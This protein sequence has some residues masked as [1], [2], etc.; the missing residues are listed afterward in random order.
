[1]QH[2]I[3]LSIVFRFLGI[4][5]LVFLLTQANISELMSRATRISV[6]PLA[7]S[8]GLAPLVIMLKA[9]RW[10]SLL[11]LQGME[12]MGSRSVMRIYFATHVIG[13]A[14]PGRLGD[15]S[16]ALYLSRTRRI[17]LG[18]SLSSVLVD[19]LLDVVFMALVALAGVM[20]VGIARGFLIPL[21]PVGSVLILFGV[22]VVR[23]GYLHRLLALRSF[24]SRIAIKVITSPLLETASLQLR[25]LRVGLIPF[26][27]IRFLAPISQTIVASLLYFLLAYCVAVGLQIPLGFEIIAYTV[28]ITSIAS[29]MP[30]SISGMGV[31]EGIVVLV[32][33]KF[34]IDLDTSL[35][36]S[37]LFFAA[38][39]AMPSVIG[40]MCLI[41]SPH[42]EPGSKLWPISEQGNSQTHSDHEG[43]T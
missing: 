28:A 26:R 13:L 19:R 34:G 38:S 3:R 33:S 27:T 7:M 30:I 9:L 12:Y 41:L 22:L 14:T 4:F 21:L 42:H 8:A 15:F 32:F 23:L 2:R 35:A 20:V 10:N 31:R 43:D 36:F 24:V 39:I 16:R 17:T 18:R 29:L 11:R 40:A 1:M 37:L 6:L 25:T 5:V